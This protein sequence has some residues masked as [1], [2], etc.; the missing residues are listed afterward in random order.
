MTQTVA[1]FIFF[2]ST[3][4]SAFA[5]ESTWDVLER[6]GLTGIWSVACAAPTT[7]TNFRYIYSKDSNGR[8]L[9]EL[10]F[11]VG[12]IVS[13]IVE[14]AELLSPSTLKI[15]IRSTNPRFEHL[16]NLVLE[17]VL[18]K[19][20]NSKTNEMRIRFIEASDSAGQ[21]L[22]KDGYIKSGSHTRVGKPTFWQYK[23][24]SA[25]S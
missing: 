6:F 22:I 13:T 10:D 4:C 17:T 7:V 25:M 24:R 20:I 15:H 11:G 16:N 8:A 9:R 18:M 1:V 21:V 5:A 14:S 3:T 2:L 19:A 23:C 12:Q